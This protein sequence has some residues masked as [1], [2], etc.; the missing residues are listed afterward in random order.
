MSGADNDNRAWLKP[1]TFIGLTSSQGTPWEISRPDPAVLFPGTY[2][3]TTGTGGNSVTIV[4][5]G[6]CLFLF[7]N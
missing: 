2:D 7:P 4:S 1:H 5:K 3:A 6:I